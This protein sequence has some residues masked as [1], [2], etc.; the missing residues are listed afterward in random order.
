MPDINMD[1]LKKII[2]ITFI[3]V[4]SFCSTSAQSEI[5][6]T[7][8][9]KI[10]DGEIIFG[11]LPNGLSY[12]I[13]PLSTPQDKMHLLFY[14]KAGFNHEET[15]QMDFSHA[16]EHLAF[17][18]SLHFPK[19]ISN[20]VELMNMLKMNDRDLGGT[21]GFDMTRFIF[22]APPDNPEAVRVGLQWFKDIANN[23]KL[24]DKDIAKERGIL[25]Q[26]FI[27]SKGESL[28]DKYKMISSLFPCKKDYSYFFDHNKNFSQDS[29][30][31]FYNQW[32]RPD[33]MAVVIVGNL[34][35]P[36]AME[37]QIE[38]VFASLPLN[39]K[40][41]NVRNC[42][43]I[44]FNRPPQ[45]VIESSQRRSLKAETPGKVTFDFFIRQ[46][47]LQEEIYSKE[48]MTNLLA[49]QLLVQIID[50][51][52]KELTRKYNPSIE[53]NAIDA[54]K[55]LSLPQGIK[56]SITTEKNKEMRDLKETFEVLHQL[57]KFGVS[58]Q[59]LNNVKRE[60]LEIA[61]SGNPPG[62]KYWMDEIGKHFIKNEILIPDKQS[63]L[64]KWVEGISLEDYNS[65]ILPFLAKRPEDIG[66]IVP[67]GHTALQ[68][69]ESKVRGWIQ[70]AFE[71][72]V[73]PY[74]MPQVPVAL[75]DSLQRNNL[76]KKAYLDKGKTKFGASELVLENGVKVILM[77]FEPAAGIYKDKVLIN[78]I[79]LKGA[80]AYP[81]KDF[82]SA[83][84]A[85]SI[86][87]N[88]GVGQY[89]KFMVER[90][91]AATEINNV[92]P[93]IGYK[94]SGINGI[95][96]VEDLEKMMGLI[97][98][99]F[100]EP[101]INRKAFKDWKTNQIKQYENPSYNLITTDFRNAIKDLTKD[102]YLPLVLGDR[103]L[104]GTKAYKGL[105]HT[106]AKNGLSIYKHIFGNARDFTFIISG[107]FNLKSVL[108]IVQKYLGNLPNTQLATVANRAKPVETVLP[109]GPATHQ[110][111]KPIYDMKG[112]NYALTYIKPTARNEDWKNHLKVEILATLSNLLVQ[113]LRYEKGYSLYNFG[114]YG[115][116][117]KDMQRVEII[118]ELQGEP[119][120]LE[121]IR[122]ECKKIVENIKNGEIR[123]E[124]FDQALKK[125][126]HSNS[127]KLLRN[128]RNMKKR[129]YEFYRYNE[130]WLDPVE[131]ENY[132]KSL[133]M[134]DIIKSSRE[135]YKEDYQYEFVMG[136]NF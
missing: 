66:V 41:I 80:S 78:A 14:V 31:S 20:N 26:E 15:H 75:M 130:S 68:Y 86:I 85:G 108:P 92:R 112:S 122:E 118:F 111:A 121:Q 71:Q 9:S 53:A 36:E 81:A 84:N 127:T 45:F 73:I 105:R 39:P 51:R 23:L 101:R 124:F 94:E 54:N 11:K 120:E 89:D 42:D 99:Y 16:I 104:N 28:I 134:A 29:L 61:Q 22:N 67:Q 87:Q 18:G 109:P 13:K 83:I 97:Y 62:P 132:L 136:S 34:E 6:D 131:I 7:L 46:P 107:D 98:L 123:Q 5:R 47:S 49:F 2:L 103:Q 126:L 44:F 40:K 50:G 96:G 27:Y 38:Q 58:Q 77:P 57:E 10:Q 21:T 133:R 70:K 43:S 74:Y 102:N 1:V 100:T 76:P 33:L 56:I 88:A 52:F 93:F 113:S 24:S 79:N 128:H 91:L 8:H 4:F 90:F 12:Y 95:S 3:G 17:D 115:K 32:Y 35:E 129:L 55:N 64:T 82:F 65:I 60:W 30:R 69:K 59:E 106:D 19:G 63:F 119:H 114:V 116:F 25:R 110:I 135:I 37:R 125:A 72:R 48:G 117:N